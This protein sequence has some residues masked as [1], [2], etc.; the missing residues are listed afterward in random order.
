MQ[1]DD[2]IVKGASGTESAARGRPERCGLGA[3]PGPPRFSLPGPHSALAFRGALAVIDSIPGTVQR[4][5]PPRAPV[6]AP[7]RA[8]DRRGPLRIAPRQATAASN[9]ASSASTVSVRRLTGTPAPCPPPPDRPA[10]ARMVAA[11][12][13]LRRQRQLREAGLR[14]LAARTDH[15][16]AR[17][18]GHGRLDRGGRRAGTARL[19]DDAR[20]ADRP[21]ARDHWRAWSRCC[22]SRRWR[23]CRSPTSRPSWQA[24]RFS[25]WRGLAAALGLESDRLA[26]LARGAGGFVGV[27]LVVKPG[28]AGF[29]AYAV[30]A[31][32]CAVVVPAAT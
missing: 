29:N 8:R 27:L 10:R 15:R 32:A 21:P 25:S 2:V 20:A 9:L 23:I 30:V 1:H 4:S 7:I 17:I 18:R 12:A 24:P 6:M 5:V 22:S 19:P 13:Y 16:A 28:L 31:L 14:E 11:M 26:A 3:R